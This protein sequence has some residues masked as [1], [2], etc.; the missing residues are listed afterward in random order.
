MEN[1]IKTTAVYAVCYAD[2][3]GHN[4]VVT[5]ETIEEAKG[6]FYSKCN[7]PEEASSLWSGCTDLGSEVKL[8]NMLLEHVGDEY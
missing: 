6:F 1:T 8:G 7:G 3:Y 2:T 5:F 4:D